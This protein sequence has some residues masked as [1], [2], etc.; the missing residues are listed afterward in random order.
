MKCDHVRQI[1]DEHGEGLLLPLD[2]AAVVEHLRSCAAC[3]REQASLLALSRALDTLPEPKVPSAFAQSIMQG[4]PEMLP[5]EEGAGHVLRWGIAASVALFAFLSGLALLLDGA[6]PD[7]A[8]Q[9]LD[10]IGASFKLSGMLVAQ[11]ATFVAALLDASATAL[12][13]S[14][15]SA[16]LAFAAVFAATNAA[17]LSLVARCRLATRQAGGR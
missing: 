2:R 14:E 6:G 3:S 5:A 10:P 17:L 15:L 8:H 13:T 16:K 9:V 11:T 12:V 4:L 7:V 1:L